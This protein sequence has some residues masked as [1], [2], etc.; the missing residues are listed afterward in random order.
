MMT[1]TREIIK[2]K[3]LLVDDEPDFEAMV[4]LKMRRRLQSGE[5]DF[6]FASSGI[7]ALYK[8]ES[9][10]YIDVAFLD[11]NMPEMDGFTL[12]QSLK[13]LFPDIMVVIVS[14]YGDMENIRQAMNLG[15]FDYLTKPVDFIDFE[16]TLNKT[17]SIA[18]KLKASKAATR[19]AREDLIRAQEE[20]VRAFE[21]EKELNEMKSRFISMIS[22]QYRTP[23]AV[24]QTSADVLQ[25]VLNH[26]KGLEHKRFID[27]IHIS[28]KQMTKMLDDVLTIG[29]GEFEK[30][31]A[32][33]STIDLIST[34]RSICHEA[35]MVDEYSHR[36]ELIHNDEICRFF[37][38]ERLFVH[39]FGNLLN[40]AL[41]NLPKGETLK[42]EI[43]RHEERCSIEISENCG[44]LCQSSIDRL[45]DPLD[46][47]SHFINQGF[48]LSLAIAKRSVEALSGKIFAECQSG[49]STKY[50]V[51]LP[52][53]EASNQKSDNRQFSDIDVLETV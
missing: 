21:K 8:I 41:A 19:Q 14:A 32:E 2:P 44:A 50:T 48:N 36:I 35:E 28:V 40:H 12:M 39:I 9:F 22:M 33:M 6:I 49:V 25:V 52:Q 29:N 1:H 26:G 38:N 20:I 10:S 23:L 34:C 18:S 4:R 43:A 31:T 46:K 53:L 47:K 27:A 45:F 11:I 37:T 3:V 13:E 16:L 51:E 7:D 42:F 5:Y 30:M 15:A 24:I 17:V